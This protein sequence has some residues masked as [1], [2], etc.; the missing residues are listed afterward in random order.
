MMVEPN[1]DRVVP[2]RRALLLAGVG[3]G[4]LGLAACDGNSSS[5]EASGK[6]N[7]SSSSASETP[8]DSNS[9]T[10]SASGEA[11]TFSASEGA[12][13]T[14]DPNF[15]KGYSGGEKAPEGEYRPADTRG[16]AQNVSK[17][18]MP[19]DGYKLAT[20]E[21]LEKSVHAWANWRN[22]G[23]ETGDYTVARQ[24]ISPNFSREVKYMDEKESLYRRGGWIVEGI[25]I[26]EFHGEPYI[27]DDGVYQWEF[28]HL[29]KRIMVIQPNGR[30]KEEKNSR[31]TQNTFWLEAK[32]DG[33]G[34]KIIT[35]YPAK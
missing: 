14:P 10:S 21:G 15:S 22:Y 5:N 16:P 2:R 26:F 6:D 30:F 29:W 34:W 13:A 24:F 23:V 35:I 1:A 32:N 31:N 28:Y 11:S 4:S 12:T 17:P 9:T 19:E 7:S 8:Q 25:S 33:N 18:A 3:L 20:V 27:K